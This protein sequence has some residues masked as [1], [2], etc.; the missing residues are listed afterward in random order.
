MLKHITCNV[1]NITVEVNY[2]TFEF[3]GG[4]R[5][6]GKV[7]PTRVGQLLRSRQPIPLAKARGLYMALSL[8]RYL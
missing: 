5:G 8:A 3:F 7:T 2:L 6:S 1:N 4:G